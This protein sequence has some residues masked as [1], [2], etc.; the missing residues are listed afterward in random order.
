LELAA[1]RGRIADIVLLSSTIIITYGGLVPAALA[2]LGLASAHPRGHAFAQD[3]D[4]AAVGNLVLAVLKGAS[5][6][7]GSARFLQE[8]ESLRRISN[9]R[10]IDRDRSKLF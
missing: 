4:D 5:S 2:V 6:S 10:I 3:A 7:S 8:A 9:E 1:G